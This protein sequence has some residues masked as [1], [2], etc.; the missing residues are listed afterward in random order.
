MRGELPQDFL[1]SKRRTTTLWSHI[2]QDIFLSGFFLQMTVFKYVE[3]KDMFQA[4]FHKMLCK[5]LVSKTNVVF[6]FSY[7]LI[8]PNQGCI[9]SIF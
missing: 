1:T 6:T 4:Y 2:F 7:D 9:K 8:N 5:R 3:D